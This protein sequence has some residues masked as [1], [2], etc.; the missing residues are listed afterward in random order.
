M[1]KLVTRSAFPILTF[2]GTFVH[3]AELINKIKQIIATIF[4]MVAQ[5]LNLQVFAAMKYD[6]GHLCCFNAE[7]S[8]QN[9]N[10]SNTLCMSLL[11]R[12]VTFF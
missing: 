4:L 5:T 9:R 12:P 10:N 7:P 11:F 2:F 6:S 1:E 8:Y 3:M